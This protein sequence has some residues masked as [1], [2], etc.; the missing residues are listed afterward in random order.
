LLGGK[1]EL[2]RVIKRGIS[3]GLRL[4]TEKQVIG[5]S[6]GDRPE[7]EGWRIEL[8]RK[9]ESENVKWV[10]EYIAQEGIGR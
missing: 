3:S 7:R 2:V 1:I 4:K 6:C 10:L 8:E 9:L 5:L